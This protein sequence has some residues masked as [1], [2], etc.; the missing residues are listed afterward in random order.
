MGLRVDTYEDFAAWRNLPPPTLR[1]DGF[2]TMGDA[3]RYFTG[4][5]IVVLAEWF[6]RW[7]AEQPEQP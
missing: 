7:K 6:K 2:V 5:P 1:D 4:T 3:M